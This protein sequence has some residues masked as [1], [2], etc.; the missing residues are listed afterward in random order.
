[1]IRFQDFPA[2]LLLLIVLFLVLLP[3]AVSVRHLVFVHMIV[4]PR[5]QEAPLGDRRIS[6]ELIRKC[7][8]FGSTKMFA[9]SRTA[10]WFSVGLAATSAQLLPLV[11]SHWEC[12]AVGHI[13]FIV[14][15]NCPTYPIIP[16]LACLVL[17][18]SL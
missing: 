6:L 16:R 8:S 13:C 1:M 4:C 14:T 17:S 11:A 15:M 5:F 18:F 3:S 10:V 12:T 2:R 9:G 7:K